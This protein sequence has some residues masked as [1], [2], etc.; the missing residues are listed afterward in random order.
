MA[1]GKPQCSAFARGYTIHEICLDI[2]SMLCSDNWAKCT[3]NV[4]CPTVVSNSDVTLRVAS[5][6]PDSFLLK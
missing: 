5:T 4:R 3:E 2:M 6:L 1:V